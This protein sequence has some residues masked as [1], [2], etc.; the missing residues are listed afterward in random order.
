MKWLLQTFIVA[1]LAAG[2]QL[3]CRLAISKTLPSFFKRVQ[4]P[5]PPEDDGAGSDDE[6]PFLIDEEEKEGPGRPQGLNFTASEML[7]FL[8]LGSFLYSARDLRKVLALAAHILG[9]DPSV[10]DALHVPCGR[11]LETR[12]SSWT[13][14]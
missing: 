1:P 8:E 9:M 12:S 3:V 10:V 11:Q 14:A 2:W 13:C 6:D 7:L 5:A 4:L